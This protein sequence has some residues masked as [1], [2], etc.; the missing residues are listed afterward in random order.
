MLEKAHSEG[1]VSKL[2]MNKVFDGS[3]VH[4]T[5][6]KKEFGGVPSMMVV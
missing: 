4:Q 6:K 3:T 2:A 5:E 1:E